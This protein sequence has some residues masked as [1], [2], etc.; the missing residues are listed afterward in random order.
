MIRFEFIK[1]WMEH[2][3]TA[4]AEGCFRGNEKA[5][6]VQTAYETFTAGPT[7]SS[8]S[9][10]ASTM[11]AWEKSLPLFKHAI[12]SSYGL[13]TRDISPRQ[14]YALYRGRCKTAS[15]AL[16]RL[17]PELS[18]QRG[19]YFCAQWARFEPHWWC[20]TPRGYIV[21]PTALQFP[22]RGRGEYKEFT[23]VVACDNCGREVSEGA[24]RFQSSYAFC[25]TQCNARFVGLDV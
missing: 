4:L 7:R 13:D 3:R 19:H 24:A 16:A 9:N 18:V 11:E 10:L 15:E 23:G 14:G 20:K 5:I 1:T 2:Q 22:C 12:A 25:S 6:A 8:E 17:H 21:D